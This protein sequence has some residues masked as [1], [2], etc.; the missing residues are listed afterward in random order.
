MLQAIFLLALAI[1]PEA[2]GAVDILP[3]CAQSGNCAL[4]DIL[5]T[6]V[7]FAE[8][9]L[10]I[11]GAVA[12]VYFIW[13]GFQMI[14]AFGDSKKYESGMTTLKHAV[15][16]I[17]IIFLAGVI[18]RFTSTALTGSNVCTA[19]LYKA[20]KCVAAA[21]DTCDKNGSLWVLM[22]GGIMNG[23]PV[24]EQLMCI[25]TDDCGALN[26]TLSQLGHKEK[27]TCMPVDNAKTCVRGLCA[28][29]GAGYACCL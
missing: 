16:G 28:S 2:A 10:G 4:T 21:G 22:P 11:S 12:L 24:G 26:S 25:A 8:F 19:S 18:V 29:K 5:A 27:Y 13:G 14:L 3:A 20:G 1:V 9:L 7:N 15:Y 23:Q 17:A 6:L